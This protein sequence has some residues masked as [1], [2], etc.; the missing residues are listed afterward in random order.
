MNTLKN[1]ENKRSLASIFFARTETGVLLPLVI[2]LVII[3][4]VN[5]DFFAFTNLV[6]ILR[7]SSY[8]FI[9]AAPL[10]LLMI[11]GG[12]DLSIAAS[13]ALGCVVCAWGLADFHIGIFP[14]ILLALAAGAVV[15]ALKAALVVTF[16]LPAFIITLGLTKIVNS[17]ILVT[18]DGI[19]VSN[20]GNESFKALGQGKAFGMVHWT[21]ILAVVIGVSMHILLNRTKFGRAV[22]ACGGNRETAKLAG[23]NVVKTRYIV[24][25]MVS[26]FAAFCG[27]C[28]CSRFN[29]GQPAAGAGTELT[30]MA[31]VIIG[32]TSMMGGSGTI[33]G[34]F[35][36]CVLL[37]VINNGLVLMRVS[38]NWQNMIFGLILVI[39]LF[40]DRYRRAKSG[41]GL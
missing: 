9:I 18:T 8:T 2:L 21:I 28:M 32:G 23:I 39:S 34:S 15:G 14:S 30:I 22:A 37:A 16:N 4:C 6:D 27:V 41:G 33:L 11:S 24:E 5:S 7:S 36:G 29:S 26:V 40:I 35:L 3:G 12:M 1:K 25:I 19:A 20:L 31:S 13:T 10:T 17:F 38:T